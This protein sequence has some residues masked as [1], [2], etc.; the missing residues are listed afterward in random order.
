MTDGSLD[1]GGISQSSPDMKIV[2]AL[3]HSGCNFTGNVKVETGTSKRLMEVRLSVG[4]L[5]NV[6]SEKRNV[7]TFGGREDGL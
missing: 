6:L 4:A 3:R 7:R 2:A 5:I 1:K